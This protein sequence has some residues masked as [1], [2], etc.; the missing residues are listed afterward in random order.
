MLHP[1]VALAEVIATQ[2]G[3]LS[4]ITW[5]SL[6]LTF[7]AICFAAFQWK[8][9]RVQAGQLSS[10]SGDLKSVDTSIKS[11]TE[12]LE[13]VAD[14]VS[15]RYIDKFPAYLGQVATLV[16]EAPQGSALK[17]AVGNLIPGLVSNRLLFTSYSQALDRQ[18]DLDMFVEIVCMDSAH[19]RQRHMRQYGET[20]ED[21][22]NWRSE[23]QNEAKIED[24]VSHRFPGVDAATVSRSQWEEM[25][26]ALQDAEFNRLVRFPNVRVREFQALLTVQM[27]I[28]DSQRAIFSLE[29]S[30]TSGESRGLY[31]QDVRFVEALESMWGNLLSECA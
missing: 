2:E 17:I 20:D 9:A 31:T 25:V 24:L 29:T 4:S 1:V 27:W 8:E 18:I 28:A 13:S 15:T 22:F 30:A 23:R 12:N 3:T 7:L 21:W 10:V 5:A 11:V 26:V 16:N 14:A 19:R 6:L